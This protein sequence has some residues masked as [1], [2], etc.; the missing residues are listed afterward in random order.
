MC[1]AQS[2]DRIG[3]DKMPSPVQFAMRASHTK[4]YY[5]P[6]KVPSPLG[7]IARGKSP[8]RS[9]QT[10]QWKEEQCEV[11]RHDLLHVGVTKRGI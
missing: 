9:Q 2:G 8:C 5:T 1:I 7:A 3:S 6:G 10:L 4:L 11:T